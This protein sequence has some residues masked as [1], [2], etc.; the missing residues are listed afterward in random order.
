M[1]SSGSISCEGSGGAGERHY[2]LSSWKGHPGARYA[3]SPCQVT[4]FLERLQ[5]TVFFVH[6]R[7]P[8]WDTTHHTEK[9][10]NAT[11][12]DSGLQKITLPPFVIINIIHRNLLYWGI[13]WWVQWLGLGVFTSTDLGFN[14]WLG[15]YDHTS[16]AAWPKKKLLK[17]ALDFLGGTVAKNLPASAGNASLIPGP[18]GFHMPSSN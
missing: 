3:V 2:S 14:P 16:C 15:N 4:A 7:L 18:G 17:R 11:Q 10:Q 12:T 6:S 1:Q 8:A 9:Q 13:P 5:S